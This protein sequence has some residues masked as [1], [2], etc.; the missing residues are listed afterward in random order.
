[1]RKVEQLHKKAMEFADM[2]ELARLKGELEE[3]VI[4]Y[5]EKAF[6][7][8]KEA[9]LA[10][11]AKQITPI[12]RPYLIRSA[13]AL[14]FRANNY[15]AA[16]KMIALGLSE[17]PS[18]EVT[19]QLKEIAKLIKKNQPIVSK[20]TNIE[21]KGKFLAA[22]EDEYEIKIKTSENEQFYSIFVPAKTL[23][24]IVRKYFSEIVNIQAVTTPNGFI[25][26]KKISLAA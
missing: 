4:G 6:Y 7:Y 15:R 25:A 18:I 21:L 22:D 10:M 20:N 17:N 12:P 16:E 13:A 1:M 3:T 5:F 19:N 14:A 8:E 9:A 23:K 11:P 26:L 24:G 2:A